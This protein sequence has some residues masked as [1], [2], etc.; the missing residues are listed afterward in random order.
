MPL[1][2]VWAPYWCRR[3]P[4]VSHVLYIS[5]RFTSAQ[6]NYPNVEKEAYA[7]IFALVKL[8]LYLYGADVKIYTD[9]VPLHCL[10]TKEIKNMRIQRWAILLAEYAAPILYMKGED[11]TWADMLSRLRPTAE[12]IELEEM[13][14]CDICVSEEAIPFG[15]YQWSC[16]RPRVR[17]QSGS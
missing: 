5:G 10:F 8:R 6:L 2:I 16:A 9:H 4:T 11:N 12:A 13:A 7:L 3:I 1:I 15:Y 14:A 17:C